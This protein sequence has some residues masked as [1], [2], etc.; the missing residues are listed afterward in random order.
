VSDRDFVL[1]TVRVFFPNGM[2][3]LF[4]RSVG[5]EEE[6]PGDPGPRPHMIRW[7]TNYHGWLMVLQVMNVWCEGRKRDGSCT[8]IG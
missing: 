1:R 6:V 2:S 3:V 8:N 7:D 4:C 5:P